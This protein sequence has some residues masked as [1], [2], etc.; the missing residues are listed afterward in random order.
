MG[1]LEK[2]RRKELDF[3]LDVAVGLALGDRVKKMWFVEELWTAPVNQGRGYGGALLDT[4]TA[5]A[6]WDGR[7]TW[8]QSSNIANTEFYRK[9]G[10]KAVGT[11]VVGNNNPT[12]DGE[13]VTITIVSLIITSKVP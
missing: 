12:W 13:P 4:V 2:E 1:E 3:K 9:H 7:S 8:L 11:A 5:W 6:D 10:F